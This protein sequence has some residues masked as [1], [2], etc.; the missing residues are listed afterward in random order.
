MRTP[1]LFALA[2]GFT[3]ISSTACSKTA[4]PDTTFTPSAAKPLPPPPTTLQSHD[5]VVG[6]GREAKTGDTVNVQ[7]TGTLLNG[8]K[9]DSSYDN[10]GKPFSFTIGKG[11]VI[12]G[13]D[14]GVP[15]MK[16]GGKRTLTIPPDLGYGA[17][18]SPP[19]IPGGAGLKFVIELVSI[20]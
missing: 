3:T 4:E 11:M 2:L 1:V 9:F 18:G 15:G 13:W 5:D 8:D 6:T 16:I 14:Q 7:Y 10:G 17:A 19:K 12:K 20:D